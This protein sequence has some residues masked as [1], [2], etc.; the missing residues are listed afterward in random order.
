[1]KMKFNKMIKRT[2]SLAAAVTIGLLAA[3]TVS[4]KPLVVS[5]WDGYMAPDTMEKFSAESGTKAELV[6]HATNEEII[7]K[8]I[9]SGGKGYDVVFVSSHY[10]EVLSNKYAYCIGEFNSN[11]CPYWPW[12]VIAQTQYRSTGQMGRN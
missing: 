4:A 5:N 9:A 8:I 10:A 2:S 7:G 6:L 3:T 11:F 1:M 12:S